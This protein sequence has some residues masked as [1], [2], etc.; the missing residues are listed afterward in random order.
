MQCL[1]NRFNLQLIF[2]NKVVN[3]TIKMISLFIEKY[4]KLKQISNYNKSN[5]Y[6]D[7]SK[8]NLCVF[9]NKTKL[10]QIFLNKFLF[11]L[12]VNAIE[13]EVKDSD[14]QNNRNSNEIVSNVE[15]NDEPNGEP[16]GE[17]NDELLDPTSKEYIKKIKTMSVWE[18]IQYLINRKKVDK[19]DENYENKFIKEGETGWDRVKLMYTEWVNGEDNPEVR[20]IMSGLGW[21]LIIGGVYGG[22]VS[23]RQS[24]EDFIRRHNEYVFRGQFEAKR[25]IGDTMY[26][27]L[28]ARGFK[29]GW[30]VCLFSGLFTGL[31]TT[32]IAYRNDIYLTDCM[33]AGGLLCGLWKIKLGL[34]AMAVSGVVGSLFGAILGSSFKLLLWTFNT[35][36]PEYRHWRHVR[37]TGHLEVEKYS[38]GTTEYQWKLKGKDT[39]KQ[40]LYVNEQ[41]K[42]G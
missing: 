4:F 9:K 12:K 36:V 1:L 30:R 17:P 18:S 39:K 13:N 31:T 21:G 7:K 32:A 35:T 2:V 29:W 37:Y 15:P 26:L 8:Q 10:K 6:L 3:K 24:T 38:D 40:P 25:K 16:N 41:Q 42:S 22:I 19:K 11:K 34:R 28:V 23:N 14:N 5:K 20:F 27:N 33:L